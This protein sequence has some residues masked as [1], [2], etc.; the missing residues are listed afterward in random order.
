MKQHP[1]DQLKNLVLI[2]AGNTLYALG[3]VMFILPGGMITGGTTGIALT[4]N[5]YFHVPISVFVF[6][7]NLIMFIIGAVVLGKKF[8]LTTL[9]S[10]FYYPFIL[11]VL[12]NVPALGNFTNDVALSTIFGGLMIGSAIGI[13]IRAGASTGG[14]D[15]PPLVLNKKFGIPVSVLLYVF[16]SSILLMQMLFS[17]KDQILY[18]ILLVMIYTVVLDKV[19]LLGTTQTQV[20]VV[21]KKYAEINQAIISELDRGS[22]LI[23]GETGY[24]HQEQPLVLSVVSNRE[25]TRLNQIVMGI[26]PSAFMIISKVNEVK[27]RGFSSQK[28]YQKKES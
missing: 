10:T 16:D 4:V 23:Y 20:K 13:V 25:L 24:L 19:L 22:T 26:D 1:F 6:C 5:H 11:G 28:I 3:V 14:M 2:F 12:E 8:A 15:I 21:S 27:G 7:F 18:G 9:I 17:N